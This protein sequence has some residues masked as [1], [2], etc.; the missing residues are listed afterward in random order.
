M[1]SEDIVPFFMRD[2]SISFKFQN[3]F[4]LQSPPVKDVGDTHD[5]DLHIQ[6]CRLI[7]LPADLNPGLLD[8]SADSLAS[9]LDIVI[10]A[11]TKDPP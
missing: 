7:L 6:L 2:F 8:I 5:H 3:N 11:D 10:S 1:S 9:I 4:S